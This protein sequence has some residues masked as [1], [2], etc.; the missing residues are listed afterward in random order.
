MTLERITW[1]KISNLIEE[2]KVEEIGKAYFKKNFRSRLKFETPEE[3]RIIKVDKELFNQGACFLE[4]VD[5][6]LKKDG[7]YLAKTNW[8]LNSKKIKGIIYKEKSNQ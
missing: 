8:K 7:M 2:N 1:G 3:I 4:H 6:L 5:R